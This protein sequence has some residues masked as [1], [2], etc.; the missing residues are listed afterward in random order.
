MSLQPPTILSDGNFSAVTDGIVYMKN[1]HVRNMNSPIE[2]RDATNKLYV[3]NAI[4]VQKIK[5]IVI[6]QQDPGP[7]QFSSVN[8]AISSITDAGPLN[9]YLI[10]IGPGA[11]VESPIYMKSFVFLMGSTLLETIITPINNTDTIIIGED[12]SGIYNCHITG[13]I[14]TSGKGIYFSS[15]G[16]ESFLVSGCLLT[17]CETLVHTEGL[18][19][20]TVLVVSECIARGDFTQGFITTNVSSVRTQTVIQNILYLDITLPVCDV[21]GSVSGPNAQL[22]IQSGLLRILQTSGTVGFQAENGGQLYLFAVS[23]NGFETGIKSINSGSAPDIILQAITIFNSS[24]YDVY[25]DH[26]DTT[27]YVFGVTEFLKTVI[28]K[29]A[30]FYIVSKDSNVINVS[31]KGGDFTTIKEAMDFITDNSSTNGYQIIVGPGIYTEDQIIGKAFVAITGAGVYATSVR[32]NDPTI[33][34]IVG[35]DSFSLSHIEFNGTMNP[36]IPLIYYS[37]D[38]S[39]PSGIFQISNCYLNGPSRKVQLQGS[40]FRTAVKLNVCSTTSASADTDFV[41]TGTPG[42]GRTRL[43]ID[44][45]AYATAVNH[46][47]TVVSCSGYN[48]Y[49]TITDSLFYFVD[50]PNTGTFAYISDQGT[51]EMNLVTILGFEYGVLVDNVGIDPRLVLLSCYI[52][53]CLNDIAIQ[54]SLCTGSINVTCDRTKVQVNSE[55][56]S[57]FIIDPVNGGLTTIGEFYLGPTVSEL[58]P[59]AALIVDGSAMGVYEGGTITVVSGLTINIAAGNGYSKVSTASINFAWT[60]TDLLLSAN[61]N[62]YVYFNSGHILSVSSTMPDLKDNILLGRVVTD[63]S[64]VLFIDASPMTGKLYGND[65]STY[66]RQGIGAVFGSGGIVSANASR[67]LEVSGGIYFFAA[68]KFEPSGESMG[69]TFNTVYRSNVGPFGFTYGSATTVDNA[70]YNNGLT[71][72]SIP[73]LEYAKHSLYVVGDGL[74]EKYFFVYAQTTNASL[75]TIEDEDI[76]TPPEFFTD[77]VTLIA[78]IIVR[79]GT[80]TIIEIIDER[81]VIGFKAPATSAAAIHGNLLG[82]SANDHPQYLLVNGASSMSGA[83]NLASNSITNAS[84]TTS[85]VINVTTTNSSGVF[86]ETLGT[87]ATSVG[88]G[89]IILSG[90]GGIGVGGNVFAN[91]L[92]SN[93]YIL[94]KT[95]VLNYV[96]PLPLTLTASQLM[97][98]YIFVASTAAGT[99]TLPSVSSLSTEIGATFVGMSIDFAVAKDNNGALTVALGTGMTAFPSS[100]DLTIPTN[101][102]AKY[103]LVFTSGTTANLLGYGIDAAF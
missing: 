19:A 64:N 72:S 84:T 13:A 81:P 34:M 8:E 57:L 21:F 91:K 95:T 15:S 3:D 100:L 7:D 47:D 45:Y 54:N 14:G 6:V 68:N 28:P 36:T 90:N 73:A 62:N 93:N 2:D 80:S 5:N 48:A 78:S 44:A 85:T 58:T 1:G 42:G 23:L 76:P 82:L 71:L 20:P 18:T 10:M 96:T 39:N 37:S 22:V 46:S 65:T 101:N 40:L 97:G 77:G 41:V 98:Q 33:P 50:V 79:Q 38:G 43:L 53:D 69:F 60:S 74:N 67:N 102:V 11:Y 35:A 61:T 27:G 12:N 75:V 16:G 51:L 25:I 86:N 56:I 32:P 24:L 49:V 52:T 70:N 31:K 88:S 59:T 30:P 26:P 87:N 55:D 89:S 17:N 92:F 4:D 99:M 63:S 66:L 83:L 9:P 103:L 29:S 94:K